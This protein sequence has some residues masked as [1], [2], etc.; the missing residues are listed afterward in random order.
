MFV[1]RTGFDWNQIIC[2]LVVWK[3]I[4]KETNFA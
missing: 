1:D 2:E 4:N 3:R